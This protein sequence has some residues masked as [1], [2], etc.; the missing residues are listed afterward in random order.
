MRLTLEALLV[1]N[2]SLKL[3]VLLALMLILEVPASPGSCYAASFSAW[4]VSTI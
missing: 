4:A 3:E 2:L 1:V